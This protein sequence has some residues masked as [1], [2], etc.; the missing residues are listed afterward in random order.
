[1]NTKG[2]GQLTSNET[3][4]ADIWFSGMKTAV[5]TMNFGV[6]Y[7]GPSKTSHK[8]F[9]LDILEIFMKYWP[10]GSY[11]IMKNTPRVPDVRPL[12]EIGHNYNSKKV[13]FLLLLRGLEVLN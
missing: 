11:P 13:L 4:F 3:Y 10:I 8:A 12:M 7:C 9:C 2:C 5:E 6:N 1:M